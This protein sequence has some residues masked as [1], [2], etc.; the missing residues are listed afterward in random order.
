MSRD[1]LP[2]QFYEVTLSREVLAED[3]VRHCRTH[4]FVLQ[5]PLIAA[6]F[7]LQ[8]PLIAANFV[9]QCPLIAANLV[10]LS[11]ARWRHK[12]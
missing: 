12:P 8:C 2:L 7:V 5:C 9:L 10:H 3:T 1:V 4:Y 11:Y 6:N